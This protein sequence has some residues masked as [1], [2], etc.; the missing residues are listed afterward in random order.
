MQIVFF[1]FFELVPEDSQRLFFDA[2]NIG[3][4]D[5]EFLCDF[6]LWLGREGRQPVAQADDFFLSV[7][8]RALDETADALRGQFSVEVSRNVAVVRYNINIGEGTGNTPC[9]SLC[10]R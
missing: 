8:E 9:N 6:A 3:T 1:V 5:T 4:G 2:R 10:V 7:V